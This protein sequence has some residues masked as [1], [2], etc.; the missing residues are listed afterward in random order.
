MG[1]SDVSHFPDLA[2]NTTNTIVQV[3]SLAPTP[4]AKERWRTPR[5]RDG[6]ATN[7][8]EPESL[9]GCVEQSPT[10]SLHWTVLRGA[11]LPCVE[12]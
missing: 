2:I 7:W 4:Y 6:G 8:K 10:I 9:N 11:K 12:P 1:G 3:V 5:P